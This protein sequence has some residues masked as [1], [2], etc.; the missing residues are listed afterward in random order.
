MVP[1]VSSLPP[2]PPTLF[3]SFFTFLSFSLLLSSLFIH[4]AYR[5]MSTVRMLR[6]EVTSAMFHDG[7]TQGARLSERKKRENKSMR[8]RE[9][10][11]ERERR[12]N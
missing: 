10:E 12:V 2:P 5:M 7:S 9:R 3:L 1:D 11:R 6:F 4:F 8:E